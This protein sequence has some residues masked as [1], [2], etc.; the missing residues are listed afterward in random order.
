MIGAVINLVTKGIKK[1]Q[2]GKVLIV[3]WK[4]AVTVKFFCFDTVTSPNYFCIKQR[5]KFWVFLVKVMRG[6]RDFLERPQIFP[7]VAGNAFRISSNFS[8][9]ASCRMFRVHV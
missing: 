6:G 1:E 3:L 2:T 8:I 9:L 7:C 5:E 4:K